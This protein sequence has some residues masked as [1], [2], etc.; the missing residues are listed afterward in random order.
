MP[1]RVYVKICS[2]AFR[3]VR[4]QLLFS[5]VALTASMLVLTPQLAKASAFTPGQI[6][7][8]N[9]GTTLATRALTALTPI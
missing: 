4:G 5:C 7:G 3:S 6:A 8:L 2:R 1:N 9:L